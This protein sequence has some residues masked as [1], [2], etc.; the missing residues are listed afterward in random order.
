[1]KTLIVVAVYLVVG[2]LAGKLVSILADLAGGLGVIV[3]SLGKPRSAAG[4]RKGTATFLCTILQAYI[5][6]SWMAFVI[7]YTMLINRHQP[8]IRWIVWVV[9]VYAA[10]NPTIIA[11]HHS[12][13]EEKENPEL[14]NT[15]PHLSVS[16][17]CLIVPISFILFILF[18]VLMLYGWSWIPHVRTAVLP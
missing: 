16:F 7:S 13:T 4:Q 17:N 5:F 12:R 14:E 18:P 2:S 11:A 9:A 10:I 15:A 8:V 1:M 3:G 6:L